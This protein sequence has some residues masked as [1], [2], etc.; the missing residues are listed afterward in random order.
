MIMKE[1]CEID[2]YIIFTGFGLINSD[3]VIPSYDCSFSENN[4]LELIKRSNK[5]CIPSTYRNLLSIMI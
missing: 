1:F 5:L 4:K 2:Y 3:Q